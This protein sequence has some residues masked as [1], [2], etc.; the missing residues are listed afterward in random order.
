M[1]R[2][3][4]RQLKRSSPIDNSLL[5]SSSRLN[6]EATKQTQRLLD[7]APFRAMSIGAHMYTSN[8]AHS[9]PRL[10]PQ[11]LPSP[12]EAD[13]LFQD[14]E[15]CRRWLQREESRITADTSAAL[16]P[17]SYGDTPTANSTRDRETAAGL[18]Q[19]LREVE[20]AIEIEGNR[21]KRRAIERRTDL[22][23]SGAVRNEVRNMPPV[24]QRTFTLTSDFSGFNSPRSS[25]LDST[26]TL[27]PGQATSPS[28]SPT[29]SPQIQQEQFIPTDWGDLHRRSSSSTAYTAHSSLSISPSSNLG[30]PSI[31]TAQ[32]TPDY[33]PLQ[34]QA[35][36]ASLATIALGDSALSWKRICKRVQVS[37]K[38]SGSPEKSIECDV[39]YRYREDTGL[40][41]RSVYKCPP[42]SSGDKPT[43][44]PWVIQ[45]FPATGPAIPLST[46]FDNEVSISFP[47]SS[48]GRLDNNFT[49]VMYTLPDDAAL[50]SA[51]MSTSKTLQTLLYTNNGKDSAD[52]LF[53]RPVD[54]IDSDLNKPE[55]RG[56][57][58]RLWCRKELREGLNGE[59]VV[60]A[61][62]LV[63]LF[64]TT[65]LGDKGHWVEEPHY[66]FQ[67]L[68]ESVY[69]NEN[70]RKLLLTFS[71]DPEKWSGDKIFKRRS[72]RNTE[73]YNSNETAIAT[74]VTSK[75]RR[76][77]VTSIS[78][79]IS[80][81][82]ERGGMIGKRDGNRERGRDLNRFRYKSLEIKFGIREDRAH[83]LKIWKQFVKPLRV[84]E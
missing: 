55:C 38:A 84:I 61:D 2:R 32:T 4:P 41:L 17:H 68:D 37:R 42:K 26:A 13:Q 62:V 44:K 28:V 45:N 70:E 64:Y 22:S 30:A 24:P 75:Q 11:A 58:I 56:S 48:C 76:D 73:S 80:F 54:K 7:S 35:S 50:G 43:W 40:S 52:L 66:A 71:K 33:F 15:F 6:L 1:S 74:Q 23:P 16:R 79:A 36:I 72:S 82:S 83:F 77:T 20:D 27:R 78:S 63:L 49:D 59:G 18:Y 65:S 10:S 9:I 3:G 14:W 25:M 53:D 29:G 67:W 39:Y 19:L 31:H 60:I 34:R 5:T 8:T 21:V 51:L 81:K 57:N 69:K 12:S 47:R 46:T